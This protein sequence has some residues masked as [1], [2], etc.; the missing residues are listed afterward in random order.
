MNPLPIFHSYGLTAGTLMP[1]L[2]GMKVVLYPSPLHYKEIPKLIGATKATILFGTDTFLQGYS[3]AAD[4][5]DLKTVRFVIAGAERVKESTKSTWAKYGTTILEGYGATEC[6]PVIACSLPDH[7]KPGSVGTVLPG[8]EVRLEPVP[9]IPE[10]GRLVVRGPNVMAGYYLADKPGV[11]VAAK[12]GWHDTGDIV[13]IDAS[14]L[15]SIKGRAKR[16]AKIGGEMVSLAAVE[17]VVAGLWPD[18]N[19]VV[20]SVADAKRGEQLI[21]VT[22]KGDA[23]RGILQS[24]VKAQGLPELWT[25][26]AIV[27]VAE[28][29]MLA[30]GKVDFMAAQALLKPADA[31]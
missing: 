31:L 22:D 2:N 28:I 18:N 3:R 21:L 10:G 9:G 26:R 7:Q 4:P 12:D 17:G 20:L 15:M 5:G 1:L 8:I 25:P 19:H 30:S 23:E 13:D 27:T 16:F 14:G 11:L 24:A 6:A 29:P